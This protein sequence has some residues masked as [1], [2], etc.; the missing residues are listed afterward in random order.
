MEGAMR[1]GDYAVIALKGR[2]EVPRWGDKP[3]PLKPEAH[4]IWAG[5]WPHFGVYENAWASVNLANIHPP[6]VYQPP[7]IWDWIPT[8]GVISANFQRTIPDAVFEELGNPQLH[9]GNDKAANS[10]AIKLAKNYRWP[11]VRGD[12]PRAKTVNAVTAFFK[13]IGSC[14]VIVSV[15][16]SW[17][18]TFNLLEVGL[19]LVTY[20]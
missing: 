17:S 9:F 12:I 18:L 7:H 14:K 6:A 20:R 4:Y 11:P 15:P 16:V 5:K 13:R 3:L 19:T 10:D 1:L 8:P 2:P